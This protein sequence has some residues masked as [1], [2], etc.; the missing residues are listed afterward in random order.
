MRTGSPRNADFK[1]QHQAEY[2][3]FSIADSNPLL[4]MDARRAARQILDACRR[5]DAEVVLT[6]QA[7]LAARFDSLFPELS[8]DLMEVVAGMLPGPVPGGERSQKGRDSE[9]RITRSPLTGLSRK[10]E[11]ELNQRA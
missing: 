1:G 10:A 3:W 8:A 11:R 9:S 2:A 4:S 7:K 6:T 5:G